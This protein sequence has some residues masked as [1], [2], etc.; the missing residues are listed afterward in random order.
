MAARRS[1]S[2]S[3]VPVGARPTAKQ[4]TSVSR[5]SAIATSAPAALGRGRVAH[6]SRQVVLADHSRD[7]GAR[8]LSERVGSTH[9][10]FELGELADH[11][12]HEIAL[13]EVRAA[14]ATMHR[15]GSGSRSNAPSSRSSVSSL[16]PCADGAEALLEDDA[17]EVG[18]AFGERQLQILVVKEARVGQTRAHHAIVAATNVRRD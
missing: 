13:G 4:P 7:L 18:P 12:R 3:A 9:L 16:R 17:V 14:P 1:A 15:V 11:Q 5:R 8:T 2:G 10:A 6:A